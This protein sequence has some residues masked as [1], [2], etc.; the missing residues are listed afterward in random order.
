MAEIKKETTAPPRKWRY[1]GPEYDKGIIVGRELF[2]P[3]DWSDKQ[4]QEYMA[5]KY[6]AFVS[7]WFTAN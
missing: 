1:V 2:R 6:A 7:E 5:G 3:A 4:I